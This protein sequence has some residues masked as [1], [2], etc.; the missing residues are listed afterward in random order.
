ML[1]PPGEKPLKKI[2]RAQEHEEKELKNKANANIL[3]FYGN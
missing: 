1:Q 3:D 2:V